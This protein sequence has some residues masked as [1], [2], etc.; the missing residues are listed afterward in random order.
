MN[1]TLPTRRLL[2]L[3]LT[4]SLCL[5]ALVPAGFMPGQGNWLELCT[6]NGMVAILVDS[7]TGQVLD[8][9]AHG[10]SSDECPWALVLRGELPPLWTGLQALQ[11]SLSGLAAAV[12]DPPR[13][14]NQIRPP[15]RAPPLTVSSH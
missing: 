13:L 7:Q 10:S 3:T 11:Q 12:F 5:R 15:V 2:L 9:L 6:A 1:F 4:L 8:P 14:S